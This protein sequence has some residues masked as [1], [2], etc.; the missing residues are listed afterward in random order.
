MKIITD[1]D[2][3]LNNT[4][5]CIGKFDGLHR[6]HRLLFL[7]A[8]RSGLKTVMITFLFPENSGI[9]G[10]EEK[11]YLAG[12]LGIDIMIRISVTDQFM[13]MSAEEFV[14]DILV[15]RCDAKKVVVGAD[16]CFG[17]RRSGTA[18]YLR[19]AGERYHFSVVVYDKLK[20][21]GEIISSTRIRRLLAEG[22]MQE[23]NDLLQTPYFIRGTVEHGNQ[24][25]GRLMVPTANI[26]PAAEK[27]LPPY[28][29]YSVRV[30][31]EGEVWD[32][33]G[34]L[35]VKP[36]IPGENPVGIEVWLF[37]YEGD[38]YGQTLIVYLMNFQRR[39]RKFASVE[40]LREQIRRDTEEARRFLG[41]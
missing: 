5:V 27:V 24:I 19:R 15:G 22:R 2:F 30:M 32:G 26:R 23:A 6:G 1:L 9:Y 18:E 17:Y 20:Q 28:G 31:I 41:D 7:E 14:R 39:E 40:G 36:T 11:I 29:V 37:D 12:E 10:Q 38:L 13:H 8:E 3:Q 33:V 4:A 35:G 16:F 25:G 34:N 21:D